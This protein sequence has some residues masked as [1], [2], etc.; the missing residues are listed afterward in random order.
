MPFSMAAKAVRKGNLDALDVPSNADAE[1][2]KHV[3]AQQL[4]DLAHS[5]GQVGSTASEE[6][7]QQLVDVAAKL[8]PFSEQNPAKRTLEG[9]HHLVYS[10]SPGGS[11]GSV[12]PFVGKVEQRF[13]D[14]TQ[15]Y[16]VVILPGAEIQLLAE[17]SIMDGNRIKV[18]FIETSILLF[19][20]KVK[21]FPVKGAGVWKQLFVGEVK[22]LI[23]GE[24]SHNTRNILLRVMEA[25]SLFIILEVLD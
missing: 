2:D 7:R 23:P 18:K 19:G 15:F 6:E 10:A 8:E 13:V 14:D 24:K 11:S 16:N 17:R 3:V 25:P 1:V 5:V 9:T 20:N 21:T 22:V 4:L 12:G